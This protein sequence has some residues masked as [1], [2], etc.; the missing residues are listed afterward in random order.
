MILKLIDGEIVMSYE[1]P[2]VIRHQFASHDFG[3]GAGAEA[4]KGIA[5]LKGRS[6]DCGLSEISEVFN[7][8]TTTGKLNVGIAAAG[9]EYI[10]M[11]LAAAAVSDVF[12]TQDDTDAIV[13]AD[14]PA[15]TQVEVTFV[16][17]T[18]GTP[19]GIGRPYV[20]IAW[21]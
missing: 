14:I 8:V 1:N 12:N 17:P 11:D 16:A 9:A 6:I 20:D 21:Y 10:A 19:T 15:D 2:I 5:G 13:L 18:G 7:G 3:A 4:I